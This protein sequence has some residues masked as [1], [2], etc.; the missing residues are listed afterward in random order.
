MAELL[1]GQILF[2]G[3]STLN[4]IE[5]IINLLG[6]PTEKDLEKMKILITKEK[7]YEM[8]FHKINSF[9]LLFKNQDPMAV[10]L[11]RRI[12]VYNPLKRPSAE[13]ILKHPYFA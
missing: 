7:L 13:Q 11:I 6:N 8:D 9:S 2:A 10:D 3:E 12:L 5:T 1:L 4:Q